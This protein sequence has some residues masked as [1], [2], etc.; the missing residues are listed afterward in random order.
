MCTV[1]LVVTDSL[2]LESPP[3]AVAVS[4]VRADQPV[5]LTFRANPSEIRLGGSSELEWETS[6]AT[7]ITISN[8][9]NTT[10]LNPESGTLSVSPADTTTYVLTAC[11]AVNECASA[12]ATVLVRPD[13]PEI[14]RFTA[15]PPEIRLGDCSTL[16]WETR[17]ASRV[18]VTNLTS[19]GAPVDVNLSDQLVVC[20]QR[21]TTYSLTATNDRGEIVSAEVTIVVRPI[22][23]V[24][25]QFTATPAEIREGETTDLCWSMENVVQA[26][27]TN[28][29]GGTVDLTGDDLV[30]GCMV[31]IR[32]QG[33]TTYTLT[34]SNDG[35][36]I[37]TASV[38]VLVRPALP[39]ILEF[40]AT[41]AEIRVGETSRLAWITENADTLT[42]TNSSGSSLPTSGASGSLD[43]APAETTT[44]TLTASS[45][46]GESVSASV[47]V[48]AKP[49]LPVITSFTASLVDPN[50]NVINPGDPV[51]LEW[52]TNADQH[53]SLVVSITNISN[54]LAA[55]GSVVVGPQSTTLYTLTVS[56][57]AGE[58]VS[59]NVIVEV[60]LQ[61]PTILQFT[62][63]PSSVPSGGDAQISWA[64]ADAVT[65]SLTNITS[66]SVIGSGLPAN[67]SVT[68]SMATSATFRLTATSAQNLTAE[69]DCNV[70][71]F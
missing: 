47:T 24:I 28:L 6:N 27:I 2:G 29:P 22:T 23:P 48:V 43:V 10:A 41:P 5:I 57:G 19:G 54:N 11:N 45:S 32:P 51:L 58:I 68:L 71:V 30:S 18:F 49:P 36:E 31:G 13:I 16:Q 35:G 46:A 65:V 17:G 40:T 33:T 4:S 39:K 42:L 34:A 53:P 20:P 67:G 25:T 55:S 56:N 62:C 3:D 37:V 66:G 61:P 38:T 60:I 15:V 26:S 21:T 7:N 52:E 44:Y 12:E 59:A 63:A 64:T 50:D 14:V 69:A 9:S 70:N 8:L 1:Q